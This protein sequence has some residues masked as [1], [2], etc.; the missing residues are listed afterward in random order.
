MYGVTAASDSHQNCA[1]G[2]N[3]YEAEA[4]IIILIF[5][6]CDAS[7]YVIISKSISYIIFLKEM[8][9]SLYRITIICA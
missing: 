3:M 2:G 1:F 5:F 6:L 7:L 8:D 4:F 9:R